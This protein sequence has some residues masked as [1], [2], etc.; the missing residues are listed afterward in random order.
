LLPAFAEGWLAAARPELGFCEGMIGAHATVEETLGLGRTR[1]LRASQLCTTPEFRAFVA[2]LA[3]RAPAL[4]AHYNQAQRAYR[5]RYGVRNA[6]RPAP[7][8]QVSADCVELPF[9]AARREQPRRRLYVADRGD[10][11]GFLAEGEQIGLLPKVRLARVEC[12]R[13]P[14]PIEADG[15]HIRLRALTLSAFARLL[16]ADLFIHGIGGAKYD[17]MTEDLVQRFFGVGLAPMCCV[18]ATVYLPLPRQGGAD[19]EVR[20]A[21]RRLRDARFNP[22]RYMPDAPAELLRRRAELIQQSAALRVDRRH[23]HA[24]RREVFQAIRS[25]NA[26]LLRRKPALLTE[27][28]DGVRRIEWQREFDRIA[29][30]REYFFA[31]HTR[32]DLRRLVQRIRAHVGQP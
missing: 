6:Q 7:A 19:E 24:E 26:E 27:L 14:W 3:L 16:L 8:L 12:H 15:W 22:Q 30:D 32:S 13:D 11:L 31:L 20:A 17:R 18:S 28:G 2:H 5:E 21:R 23:A 1:D 9:W 10:A 29:L 25:A 4:A